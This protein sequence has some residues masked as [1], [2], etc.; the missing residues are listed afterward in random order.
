[1][2]HF[3]V[4]WDHQAALDH[5]EARAFLGV[6]RA[7]RLDDELERVVTQLARFPESGQKMQIR[8][9]VW[10][11]VERKIPLSRSPYVLF[12]RLDLAAARV[13][14]LRLRHERARPLKL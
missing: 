8:R 4:G 1:M 11:E 12:Y 10:S 2:R 13:T 7:A 3:T 5:L 9:G 6:A 14:I